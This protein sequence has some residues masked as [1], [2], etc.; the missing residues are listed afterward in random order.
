MLTTHRL[1]VYFVIL[2]VFSAILQERS[3]PAYSLRS[4]THNRILINK[5][6]DLNNGIL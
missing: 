6:G 5:T 4:R 3:I 1:L 2:I